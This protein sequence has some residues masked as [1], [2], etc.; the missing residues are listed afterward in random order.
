MKSLYEITGKIEDIN[1]VLV[2]RQELDGLTK[3]ARQAL[4]VLSELAE[5]E[6][7]GDPRHPAS[8]AITALREALEEAPE[9]AAIPAEWLEEAFRDGWAMC[10][11]SEIVGEE[12]EDWAFAK[13]TTNSR[14]ID[15]QQAAPQPA[16]QPL[17][18]AEICAIFSKLD[19]LFWDAPTGF[20]RDFA[21]AVERA[22]L[23]KFNG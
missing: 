13:S 12:E 21:R 6:S 11:D 1:T 4:G 5:W 3:A 14:M 19:P 8:V 18:D 9:P 20:E 17:T 23:E 10:R 15:A 7:E 22:V 16:R 2:P